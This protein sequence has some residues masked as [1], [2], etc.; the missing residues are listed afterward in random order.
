MLKK[1]SWIACLT[2]GMLLPVS[3]VV[4]APLTSLSGFYSFPNPAN[5]GVNKTDVGF[6]NGSITA[7]Q[8]FPGP[9]QPASFA[10]SNINVT[11]A[12]GVVLGPGTL[13][14]GNTTL[15]TSIMGPQIFT[16]TDGT[17]TATYTFGNPSLLT[18]MFG[19]NSATITSVLTGVTNFSGQELLTTYDL[20]LT[21]NGVFVNPD[22]TY[23]VPGT[24]TASFTLSQ[25]TD[26]QPF[27]PEPIPE[28][29]SIAIWGI[30]LFAM[31]GF[32]AVRRKVSANRKNVCLSA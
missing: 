22:G 16:I 25:R 9:I 26:S 12:S 19:Q 29:A 31:I 2:L 1:T 28:P 3:T 27:P 10:V 8:S 17:G 14:S 21:L 18:S 32:V 11:A 24:S 23:N 20:I 13:I 5:T 4:A 6:S 30:L 15:A 7:I